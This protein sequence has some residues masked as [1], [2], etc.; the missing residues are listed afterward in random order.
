[1]FSALN[2][3][4]FSGG[5][6]LTI[7]IMAFTASKLNLKRLVKYSAYIRVFSG[8]IIIIAGIYMLLILF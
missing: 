5:F 8:L 4:I 2:M 7:L 1:M 6:S 3:L